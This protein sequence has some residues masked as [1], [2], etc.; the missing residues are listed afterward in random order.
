MMLPVGFGI[1]PP[2]LLELCVAADASGLHAVGCGELAGPEAFSLMG[3]AAAA[4]RHHP[5]G[6]RSGAGV[7]PLAGAARHGGLHA[8]RAV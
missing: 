3:A 1:E 2:D 6:D 8:G 5:P 7:Q 4:T